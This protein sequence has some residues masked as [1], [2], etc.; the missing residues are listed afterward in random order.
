[1]LHSSSLQNAFD[2]LGHNFFCGKKERQKGWREK[3]FG[4]DSNDISHINNIQLADSLGG[5]GED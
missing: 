3:I 1:M 4:Y 2:W 5:H